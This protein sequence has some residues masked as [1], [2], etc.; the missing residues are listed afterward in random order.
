[1]KK[2]A[3]AV[4]QLKKHSPHILFGA[5]IVG[6][7]ASTV[8]ACR[9][10]LK[11]SDALDK[12]EDNVDAIKKDAL[13]PYLSHRAEPEIDVRRE[14][15]WEYARGGFEITKLYAPA[16]IIGAASIAALTG[17]HIQ[18]T[19][20]NNA[21]AAA[22]V[23]LQA[24]FEKYRGRV[25]EELGEDREKTLYRE[26]QMALQS[27]AIEHGFAHPNMYAR[28]FDE[29]NRNWVPNA[30]SNRLFLEANERY[31]NDMLAVHKHVFLNDVYKN[32][33]FEPTSAGQLVGWIWNSDRGDGY[34]SFDVFD[35]SLA[36]F[37]INGDRSV[38][39]D[40]NVD[41]VIYQLI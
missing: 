18:L 17:S 38:L 30:E 19:K 15:A 7:T 37:P 31:F 5:G 13:K 10:T 35:C 2:L 27:E 41:G 6:V 33:G 1:M 3:P 34:I 14:V 23:T 39:L 32:L 20:R 24:A 8:L 12:I 25:R 16:V 22:Y 9:A 28:V 36:D 21:L 29:Q 40:F 4:L 26:S 11:V